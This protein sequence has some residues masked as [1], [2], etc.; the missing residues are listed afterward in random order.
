MNDIFHHPGEIR[1]DHLVGRLER[2]IA[3]AG[4]QS[5][6]ER[7]ICGGKGFFIR[8]GGRHGIVVLTEPGQVFLGHA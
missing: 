7:D 6:V 4:G 2:L 5:G 1:A 8:P 3:A